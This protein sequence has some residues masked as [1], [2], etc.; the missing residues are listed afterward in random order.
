VDD[1]EF[2]EAFES[3][4]LP[5]EEFHHRDHVRLAWLYLRQDSVLAA[6][7]RFS[8]GL[9]RFA[10]VQG[11]SGLYHETVTWAYIFLINERM[12]RTGRSA[13]W[14]EFA[15]RNG[16]LLSWKASILKLYYREETLKSELARRVFVLPDQVRRTSGR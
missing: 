3:C 15:A 11:K 8:E 2:I 10:Q 9:K 14:E 7:A 5:A 1:Q 16:D 6:L 12:E 4:T 13:T